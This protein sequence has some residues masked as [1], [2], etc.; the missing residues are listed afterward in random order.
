MFVK[1][2]AQL[3]SIIFSH[4]RMIIFALILLPAVRVPAA[5][6]STPPN[7]IRLKGATIDTSVGTDVRAQAP[8]ALSL[9]D[10]PR[11]SEESWRQY[12]GCRERT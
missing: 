12:R 10:G 4:I 6:A 3:E 8:A 9:P 1:T 7:T 5:Q 2:R 11:R